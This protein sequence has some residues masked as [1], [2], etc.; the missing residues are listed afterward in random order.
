MSQAYQSQWSERYW[1]NFLANFCQ[2]NMLYKISLELSQLQELMLCK[3]LNSLCDF[4][5]P[6]SQWLLFLNRSHLQEF[7][8]EIE[9]HVVKCRQWSGKNCKVPFSELIKTSV[10][11]V[12]C[13]FC[14][15][16]FS[17]THLDWFVGF[18]L[19]TTPLLILHPWNETEEVLHIFV[20]EFDNLQNLI[21]FRQQKWICMTNIC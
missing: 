1:G 17:Q 8:L 5:E 14:F 20:E 16:H 18:S 4:L 11:N 6:H 15:W 2:S 7:K 10:H 21:A 13:V 9:F 19:D 12:S 3:F